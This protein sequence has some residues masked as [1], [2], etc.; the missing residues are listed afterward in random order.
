MKGNK[1]TYKETVASTLKRDLATQPNHF[2]SF[3]FF[4]FFFFFFNLKDI[5]IFLCHL[6]SLFDKR[7]TNVTIIYKCPKHGLVRHNC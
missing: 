2:F 5:I 3:F 6:C 7:N 1:T 4:F